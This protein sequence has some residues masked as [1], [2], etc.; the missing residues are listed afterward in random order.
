MTAFP[1]RM[2]LWSPYG[3][4]Q[5]IIFLPC[6][7]FFSLSFFMVALCNKADHYIFILF[8]S[9]FFFLF[10]PRLISAVGDCMSTILWHM[11]WS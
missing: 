8:L 9:F 5:S 11:V 7:F 2:L 6:G 1:E 4:G 3:I 10:F